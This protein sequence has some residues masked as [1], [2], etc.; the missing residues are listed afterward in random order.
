MAILFRTPRLE[1]IP[2]TATELDWLVYDRTRLERRLGVV[3][4]GEPIEGA[5]RTVMTAQYSRAAEDP[6]G[7]IWHTFWLI[8]RREDR[9]V[10]GAA[11]FKDTPDSRGAI[12]IGYGLGPGFCHNGYMTEAVRAMCRFALSN[13]RVTKIIAVVEPDNHA[14][15]RVLMRCGFL[16]YRRDDYLWWYVDSGLF[17]NSITD[18]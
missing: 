16:L 13:K 6:E 9:V 15:A 4:R 5:L 8:V 7:Y 12:E 18:Q 14:S 3:Y 17:E 11:N 10:I 2:L 1:L